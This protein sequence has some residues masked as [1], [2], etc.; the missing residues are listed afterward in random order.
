MTS[1][2]ESHTTAGSSTSLKICVFG[3]GDHGLVVAEAAE[4]AGLRVL[5][6]FDDH[7]TASPLP[8]WPLLPMPATFDAD[9][10]IIVAIGDNARRESVTLDILRRGAS[11]ATVI[12]PRAFISP[13]AI[14]GSGVFV[15]PLAVVHSAAKLAD[16]VIVNSSSIV[17]HHCIIENFAHVAPNAA[18]AGRVR[19]GQRTL[20]GIGASVRPGITIG[21]DAIIGA[22]AAVVRDVPDHVTQTGVPATTRS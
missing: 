21:S 15:G 11:L 7:A 22:G 17:E 12:H 4:L 8:R 2:H 6:F 5:G 20:I 13:S 19:V 3:A 16:S 1:S 10:R 9:T 14:V 18:L